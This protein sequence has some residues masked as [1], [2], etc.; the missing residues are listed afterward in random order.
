QSPGF[1][2]TMPLAKHDLMS[3]RMLQIGK[4]FFRSFKSRLKAQ[5]VAPEREAPRK[6]VHMKLADHTRPTTSR[7]RSISVAPCPIFHRNLRQPFGRRMT[8]SPTRAKREVGR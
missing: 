1:K 8:D 6:V 2:A 4:S 5:N 3:F 7:R